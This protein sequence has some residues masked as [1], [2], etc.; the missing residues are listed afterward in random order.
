MIRV[1]RP[2][3]VPPGLAEA[4]ALELAEYEQYLQSRNNPGAPPA[5]LATPPETRGRRRKPRDPSRDFEFR[6]YKLSAVRTALETAFNG[7]CAYCESGYG[8]VITVRV[9]HY[10]PKG[11]V[12]RKG[13]DPARGYYWLAGEWTNL[14][15]CCDRCNSANS[16]FIPALNKKMTVGKANL[17]PLWDEA[18]RA[19]RSGD[20]K[21]E[22]PLLLNPCDEEPEKYLRF[23]E[24]GM[25]EPAPS[26]TRRQKAKAQTSIDLL[27][28]GGMRLVQARAQHAIRVLGQIQH[29]LE[30]YADWRAAPGDARW[31]DRLIREW[32]ELESFLA[33]SPYAPYH[34]LTKSLIARRV[35]AAMRADI[36]S[37]QA[38]RPAGTSTGTQ[39]VAAPPIAGSPPPPRRRTRSRP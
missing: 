23:D 12:R 18:R 6:A 11:Q 25:V 26:L 17:F 36:Q 1:P 37:L 13:M 39:P 30:N 24:H 34:S 3:A 20:E 14:L 19:T 16:D 35:S 5:P 28:L 21:R 2:A 27:G 38:A 9:D 31:A 32:E 15:P 8:V 33:P 29:V 7:K 22:Y 4:A 10:R